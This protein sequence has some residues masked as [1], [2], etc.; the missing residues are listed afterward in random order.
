MNEPLSTIALIITTLVMV[1]GVIGIVLP[2]IPGT[3]LIFL[4]A[5]VY[6][7]LEGFQT[8]GWGTLVVLGL[9]SVLATTADLWASTAG[10]KIGGASGWSIVIGMIGGL[11][12]FVLFNLLGAI[13]GAVLGV[14]LTEIARVGDWRQALKAGSGWL[15]GWALSTVFQLAIGLIMVAI[16]IWQV[17]K[18]P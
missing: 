4:A 11:V 9:L 18:G 16:F 12:G 5:M 15:L 1:I 13:L 17:M 8:I 7:F 10:A 6:A 2:I 14:L 3:V